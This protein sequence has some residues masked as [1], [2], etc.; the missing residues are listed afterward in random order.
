MSAS[1]PH[2]VAQWH[3]M[4]VSVT[5]GVEEEKRSR[6]LEVGTAAIVPRWTVLICQSEH[7]I[8]GSWHSCDL[9]QAALIQKKN[10][11]LRF[12]SLKFS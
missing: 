1:S 4:R 8:P 6:E 5:H 3:H 10:G 2:Y 9:P 7:S 12:L 11:V